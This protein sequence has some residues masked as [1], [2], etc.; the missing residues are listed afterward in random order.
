MR[1][2]TLTDQD[3]GEQHEFSAEGFE[4]LARRI[5]AALGDV[6]TNRARVFDDTGR[7]CGWI[8]GRGDWVAG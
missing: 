2:V 8:D 1:H 5:K 4:D 3:T 6:K 7:P